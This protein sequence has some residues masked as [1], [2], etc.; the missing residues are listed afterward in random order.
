MREREQVQVV[1]AE[2]DDCVVTECTHVAQDL[3]RVRAAIDKIAN[4]P[5]LVAVG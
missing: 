4:Q 2:Y 3:E 5:K 1:I